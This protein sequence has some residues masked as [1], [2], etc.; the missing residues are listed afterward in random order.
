MEIY[1]WKKTETELNSNTTTPLHHVL[2]GTNL[3]ELSSSWFFS[4]IQSIVNNMPNLP[5]DHINEIVEVDFPIELAVSIFYQLLSQMIL[6]GSTIF[7]TYIIT[8]L[9][10]FNIIYH[11]TNFIYISTYHCLYI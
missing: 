10:S 11:I 3:N 2:P 1:F 4:F 8:H 7:H 9:L 6:L 5:S